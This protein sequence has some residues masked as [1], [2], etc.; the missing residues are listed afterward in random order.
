[1]IKI[2]NLTKRFD[3]TIAVKNLSLTFDKGIIG[4][5]GHNGAGKSTLFRLI[6]DVILPNSGEILIDRVDYRDNSVKGNLFFLCDNPYYPRKGTIKDVITF[7]DA[8]YDIDLI[9]FNNIVSSFALPV[10]RKIN[11]FSKGMKRQLFI[12]IALSIKVKYLLLDEAF[13]GLDPLAVEKIKSMILELKDEDRTII[14]SSHNISTLD[15]L[16]D[17]YVV[18]HMG[19][20]A[21]DGDEEVI[22]KTFTKYQLMISEPIDVS[23]FTKLGLEVVSLN[24]VGS[25]YHLVIVKNDSAEEIIQKNIK[26]SLIEVVPIDTGELIT[27]E[28]LYM[29]NKEGK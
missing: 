18:L 10:K 27:I 13:D 29:K 22:S 9:R 5:V 24:K 4:L 8:F 14:V 23:S 3:D 20:V 1:M 6:A 11:G 19:Q 21:I 12:A 2:Y 26:P 28:M 16:V 15:K 7:Y 17:Q 25:I